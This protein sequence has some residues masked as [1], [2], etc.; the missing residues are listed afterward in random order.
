[1]FVAPALV[2]ISLLTGSA[3]DFIFNPFEIAAVALS[4][5]I[6]DL[7]SRDGAT[8]WL[9][10]AQLLGAYTVMAV[11]FFFVQAL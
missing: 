6:V 10:G 11:S 4:V 7:I 8:N 2:F 3:M 5:L 1:M 9:E